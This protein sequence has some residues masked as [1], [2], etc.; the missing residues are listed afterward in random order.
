ME[1]IIYIVISRER[2]IIEAYKKEE[3][4]IIKTKDQT[5]HEEAMGGRPSVR[6]EQKKLL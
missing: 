2:G 5:E 4:A 1:N 6:Y 3:D